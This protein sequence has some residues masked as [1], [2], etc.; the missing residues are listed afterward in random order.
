[1]VGPLAVTVAVTALW[2]LRWLLYVRRHP[3]ADP[4]SSCGGRSDRGAQPVGEGAEDEET[5]KAEG[6]V[7]AASASTGAAPALATDLAFVR[8]S[9]RPLS[10]PRPPLADDSTQVE[11]LPPPGGKRRTSSPGA[12]PRAASALTPGGGG[13]LRRLGS[14]F[15]SQ[16]MN[17]IMPAPDRDGAPEGPAG[18]VGSAQ[19]L[20]VGPALSGSGPPP[21]SL[22]SPSLPGT[23]T[24]SSLS[25]T[26]SQKAD[27]PTART[28]QCTLMVGG[29]TDGR[30]S[31]G[32]NS[33]PKAAASQPAILERASL[34]VDKEGRGVS[35]AQAR[36][37]SAAQQAGPLAQAD[38]EDSRE[39]EGRGREATRSVWQRLS[40]KLRKSLHEDVEVVDHKVG[41]EGGA[42]SGPDQGQI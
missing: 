36:G 5:A 18:P 9:S 42:R 13:S 6:S 16:S 7:G 25:N 37:L 33:A 19:V 38:E 2:A 15:R 35:A 12:S 8:N 11:K 17:A 39:G 24:P 10:G 41:E 20:V 26:S 29:G 30:P 23:I 27:R 1:M 40:L 22:W 3:S 32:R 21:A 34:E 4:S 31:A 28:S 14:L